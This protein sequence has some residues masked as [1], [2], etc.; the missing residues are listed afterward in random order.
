MFLFYSV[1]ISKFWDEKS[2]L[3]LGS[4]EGVKECPLETTE[5]RNYLKGKVD[6][7]GSKR[8]AINGGTNSDRISLE[9]AGEQELS[10]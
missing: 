4:K 5:K 8:K 3:E 7:L 6:E 1:N 9:T 10:A 2:K